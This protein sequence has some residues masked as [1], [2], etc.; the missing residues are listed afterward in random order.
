MTTTTR[1]DTSLHHIHLRVQVG[2]HSGVV[3]HC[4]A[5]L[6]TGAPWTEISDE[7]LVF[8]GLLDVARPDIAV[9]T[10]LQTQRY[11]KFTIPQL[12]I[13]GH[14]MTDVDVRV[15]RFN[16]LWE[17][18]ALIGLDFFRRFPAAVEYGRGVIGVG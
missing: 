12:T 15:S 4:N 6:D 18:A 16:P 9:P 11:G 1:F 3:W 10:D 7:F 13:C 2:T 8:V 17:I 14:S 5:I